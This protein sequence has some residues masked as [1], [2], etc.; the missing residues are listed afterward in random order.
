MKTVKFSILV[1][2]AV[3]FTNFVSATGNLSVNI[4]PAGENN[5]LIEITNTEMSTYEIDIKDEFGDVVFSKV[6]KAPALD[7]NKAY[8]FSVLE[9]G[10]YFMTVEIDNERIDNKLV[11]NNGL[12]KLYDQKKMIEPFFSY[13]D[14]KFKMSY[15]NFHGEDMKLYVYNEE[16]RIVGKSI[17]PAFTVN[18]GLDFSKADNGLYSVV[19][20]SGD[21]IYS[22]EIEK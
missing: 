17:E 13:E 16:D 20:V 9:D 8:D 10:T 1:I 2:A 5:A 19:F 12:V 21:R 18:E 15:L 3:L 14:Q 4:A 11:I 7:Y 22:Y 6:S